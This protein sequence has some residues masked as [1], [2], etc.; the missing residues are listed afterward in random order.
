MIAQVVFFSQ[1]G[2]TDTHTVT[3][4]ADGP[5]LTYLLVHDTAFSSSRNVFVL[6]RIPYV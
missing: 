6:E 3:D 2:H 1:H 4:A 5:C